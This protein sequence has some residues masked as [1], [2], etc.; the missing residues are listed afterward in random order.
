M[1]LDASDDAI[2]N[3]TPRD[4]FPLRRGGTVGFT[5]DHVIVDRGDETLR[6]AADR[7][8]EAALDSIDW[9]HATM[10]V[11]IIGFGV[12]SFGRSV[13]GGLA[14]VAVGLATLYLTYR[15]RDALRVHV[16]DRRKPVTIY[17]EDPSATYDALE[18]LLAERET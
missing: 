5:S 3:E 6:I 7:I 12:L 4:E 8:T 2:E 1:A 15:R 16:T 13:P 17:P 11:V 18:P 10:G 9:F 14:F